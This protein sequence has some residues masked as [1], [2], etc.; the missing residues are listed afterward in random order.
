MPSLTRVATDLVTCEALDD[1]MV[2]TLCRGGKRNA[3]NQEMA[4][5]IDLA[6]QRLDSDASLRVG[7]ITGEP[8]LFSAGTDLSLRVSP[9]AG[10]GGE[11]GLVRRVRKKPLI[12]AVEGGAYGGGFEVVLA[13]DLVVAGEDARF[14]LPEVGRGVAAVCGGLFRSGGKL[15]Q[16]IAMEM[17]LTGEHVTAR[18]AYD[19]GLVNTLTPPGEALAG[20]LAL[21]RKIAGNSPRA[22]EYT[23]Q[24]VAAANAAV[25]AELW[26]LS[27]VASERIQASPD[28][29][30]GIAAFFEKRPPLWSSA[31][32]EPRHM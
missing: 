19:V 29:L 9:R 30:E 27:D 1:V 10:E 11:Y 5:G 3:L 13:C 18:R 22:V 28:R 23:Y 24:A 16:S 14:A 25:E 15:P 26:R 17:L 12:A 31:G 32:E 2:V 8:P 7:I 6:L 21:A 4:D 20:A